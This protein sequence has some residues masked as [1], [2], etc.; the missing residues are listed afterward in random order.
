MDTIE[1]IRRYPV[2]L[3]QLERVVKPEYHVIITTLRDIDPHDIIKPQHY[4]NS[5]AEAIGLVFTLFQ[6]K[7]NSL[8]DTGKDSNAELQTQIDTAKNILSENGIQS[9]G[10]WCIED[11]IDKAKEMKIQCGK[12]DAQTILTRI[13]NEFDAEFGINWQTIADGIREYFQEKNEK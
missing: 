12:K 1:F 5:E 13:E 10:L 4:F 3:A 2:Y 9:T 11:I 7:L 6:K 8:P